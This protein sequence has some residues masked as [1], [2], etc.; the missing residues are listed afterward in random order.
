MTNLCEATHCS[1]I[2]ALE[3]WAR[4]CNRGTRLNDYSDCP[5]N[6]Q[7]IDQVEYKNTYLTAQER[8]DDALHE[9]EPNER[10][11]LAVERIVK[12]LDRSMRAAIRVHWVVLPYSDRP[13]ILTAEQWN[14]RRARFAG[15]LRGWYFSP[16]VYLET[17]FDAER[18]IEEAL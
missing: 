8:L 14:E 18:A 15:K 9:H 12:G 6:W 16:A 13:S 10:R 4:W 1:V 11:A 2:D 7:M 5:T 17:V 3:N